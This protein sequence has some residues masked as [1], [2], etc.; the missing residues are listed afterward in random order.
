MKRWMLVFC[1]AALLAASASGQ[2]KEQVL[3]LMDKAS[4][5]FESVQTDFVWDQY[6]AVVEEHDVQT[7]VMYFK[8]AGANVDVAADIDAGKPKEHKKLVF[9]GGDLKVYWF[10]TGQTT[11]KDASK[12]R[13]E[14][15]S[16][17]ALG[18][19]GSSKNLIKN[20]EIGYGGTE[21]VLG[22][23]T[24]KLELTPTSQRVKDMFNHITLWIDQQTGMSVQQKA[25][26]GKTDYRLAKYTNIRINQKLPGDAFKLKAK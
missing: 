17:L 22:K 9:M 24:Y 19:G 26:E 21:T 16:F 15:E 7:G 2:N 14:I 1:S 11:N 25:L 10:S 4:A 23:A 12:N 5:R 3:A 8:R 13:D 6:H 18:F 20:F